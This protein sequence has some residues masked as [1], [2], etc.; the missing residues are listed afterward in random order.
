MPLL[1]RHAK[2]ICEHMV[3]ILLFFLFSLCAKPRRN[4]YLET[5]TYTI[6]MGVYSNYDN[7]L[8]NPLICVGS[9]ENDY[10]G[11]ID[12]ISD[13]SQLSNILTSLEALTCP[14]TFVLICTYSQKRLC[15]HRRQYTDHPLLKVTEIQLNGVG[16]K[17]YIEL[18]NQGHDISDMSQIEL[19]GIG[20]G[21]LSATSLSQGS[22]AVI[23]N[24]ANSI[25]QSSI[26]NC[27]NCT[28]SE[29]LSTVNIANI[30]WCDDAKAIYMAC[31]VGAEC[32]NNY[33]FEV[34]T[35]ECVFTLQS[36]NDFTVSLEWT[37]PITL[38]SVLIESVT[39][40]ASKQWPIVATNYALELRNNGYN[41][42]FGSSWVMSCDTAGT[43]GNKYP[44]CGVKIRLVNI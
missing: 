29:R 39:F 7:R 9:S 26:P 15:F 44:D 43:P 30:K 10:E 42:Q 32:I 8:K 16:G 19:N 20:S 40:N 38:S 13:A 14:R 34:Y 17:Q 37:N 2:L 28:C 6:A 12:S 25:G 33:A 5:N 24:S 23:Y 1:N 3:C 41:N 21:S 11:L 27:A 31:C 36:M 22:I 18:Y 4:E 35:S